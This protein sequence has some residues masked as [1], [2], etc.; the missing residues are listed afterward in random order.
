MKHC[1]TFV[2]PSSTLRPHAIT[3]RLFPIPCLTL[4]YR[5]G[6]T[7]STTLLLSIFHSPSPR[8]TPT[9]RLSP[10]TC[11]HAYKCT[12]TPSRKQQERA[13]RRH[14]YSKLA[15]HSDNWISLLWVGYFRIF[16]FQESRRTCHS[17]RTVHT[18]EH[19][20]GES[21]A[22]QEVAGENGTGNVCASCCWRHLWDW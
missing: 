2:H 1:I 21:T 17:Y 20:W 8:L 15:T 11:S 5:T 6:V 16:A 4:V 14:T 19:C 10:L 12:W 18:Y 7:K 13:K 3:S 22:E 9:A